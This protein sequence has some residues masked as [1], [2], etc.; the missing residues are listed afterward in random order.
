[1]LDLWT[2]AQE[3]LQTR[4]S[5]LKRTSD[6]DPDLDL[7]G[8]SRKRQRSAASS[9]EADFKYVRLADIEGP[10]SPDSLPPLENNHQGLEA[11]VQIGARS[12]A[13]LDLALRYLDEVKTVYRERLDIYDAFLDI[14]KD[15]K[16]FA[17]DTLGVMNR[18]MELFLGSMSDGIP[19][20][21]RESL[22]NGF[23]NF[24]PP[25]YRIDIATR[26]V[27]TPRGVV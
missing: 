19:V 3:S 23:K 15:F 26:K 27:H 21:D 20:K 18:V 13:S 17:I 1:M 6:D 25:G 5:T 8:P 2:A 4:P 22:T 16:S 9:D 24:L 12:E 7:G 11:D 10:D 14:M